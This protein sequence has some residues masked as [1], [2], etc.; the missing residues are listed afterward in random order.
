MAQ[1]L[2]PLVLPTQGPGTPTFPDHG[3]QGP[4]GPPGADGTPGTNGTN[5]TD[6]TQGPIGPEG[7]PGSGGDGY[8]SNIFVF[9]PFDSNPGPNTF[10][11]FQEAYDKAM[12]TK[13]PAT[14]V[15][16]DT[17]DACYIHAGTY[18]LRQITLQGKLSASDYVGVFID[19][20][21]IFT[22]LY[23]IIDNL[24]L[25]YDG[26]SN[27]L[28]SLDGQFQQVYLENNS[29]F[30]VIN[31]SPFYSLINSAGLI[32]HLGTNCGT[33]PTGPNSVIVM[34][35]C[36]MEVHFEGTGSFI[37][38][39]TI[40]AAIPGNQ[41]F[42]GLVVENA[43]TSGVPNAFIDTD[44]EAGFDFSTQ[45][46]NI[47]PLEGNTSGRPVDPFVQNGMMYYD[48][49][50]GYPV[51]WDGS[52]WKEASKPYLPEYLHITIDSP[53]TTGLV[54]GGHVNFNTP[55]VS[56]NNNYGGYSQPGLLFFSFNDSNLGDNFTNVAHKIVANLGDFDGTIIYQ[57]WDIT[58]NIGLGNIAGNAGNGKSG[59]AVA[60][61]P[62]TYG[63]NQN[64][65]IFVELRLL[66]VG[67][68]TA[69]GENTSSGFILPWATMES[70]GT[71]ILTL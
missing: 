40:T 19:D 25:L 28:I 24:S 13:V 38:N 69:I 4:P 1:I 26:T 30:S 62:A 46:I 43:G 39:E 12:E 58:N 64:T 36:E 11:T 42:V 61:I 63:N 31:T 18:D 55:I 57:W 5:G 51:W 32:I 71:P 9:R 47:Q 65:N 8:G 21:V 20:Q 27:P 29:F 52:Q 59:D 16:D 2:P 67:G 34:D 15:F 50:I 35:Q 53:Q 49:Q 60:F 48:S 7:P 56:F 33:Q 44:I 10:L 45:A 37:S 41:S 68:T 17:I 22:G 6:G 70:L 3:T 23:K 66:F 54:D 14:I